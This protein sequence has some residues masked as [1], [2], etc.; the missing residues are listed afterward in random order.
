MKHV[1]TLFL[2]ALFLGFNATAATKTSTASG[3]WSA[4]VWTGGTPV[5]GDDIIIASGNVVTFNVAGGLV[6]NSLTVNGTLLM[7]SGAAPLSLTVS[8][9]VTVASTGNLSANTALANTISIGGNLANAGTV[10]LSTGGKTADLIFTKNGSATLSGAGATNTYHKITLNMGASKANV[11]NVTASKFTNALA[12]F[13]T[14]TNGTFEVSYTTASA[15]T[16]FTGNVAIGATC[17]LIINTASATVTTTAGNITLSGLLTVNLGTVTFGSAVNNNLLS[18]GGSFTVDGGTV[19]I[20]GVYSDQGIAGSTFTMGGGTLTID[21]KGSAATAFSPFQLSSASSTFNMTAGTLTLQLAGGASSN[22]GFVATCVAGTITG[23]IVQIGNAATTAG[24]TFAIDATVSIPALTLNSANA[25]ASLS[26]PLTVVGNVTLTTGKFIAN[27]L[28]VTL[29]GNWTHAAAVTWTPGTNTVTFN[30]GAAQTLALTAGTEIFNKLSFTGA[31]TKTLAS[32][33][34]VNSD[35]TIGAG[36]TF[37]VSATNY[38]VI[39]GGNW[40]DNGAFTCR[41]GLVTFNSGSAQTITDA[42]GETFNTLTLS[43]AGVKTLG[44]PATAKGVFTISAG[45]ALDVSASN[46]A[47][48][49]NGNWVDNGTFT[50][51][52]GTVTFGGAAQSITKTPGPEVFYTVAFNGTSIKTLGSAMTVGGNLSI[53]AAVTLDVGATSF[54]VTVTGNWTDNGTFTCRAGTVTF[55]GNSG[56]TITKAAGETF[57]TLMFTGTGTKTLGGPITVSTAINIGAGSTLDASAGNYAITVTGTWTDNGTFTPQLGTV[58]FNLA[59]AQVIGKTGGETFHNLAITGGSGTKTLSSAVSLTGNLS[60]A[61]STTFD[62]TASNF[63]VTV[64]GNWSDLGTFT[65]RS[66]TVTFNGSSAE[67]ITKAAGETFFLLNITGTGGAVL[68]GAITVTSNL[69]IGA[70]SSLDASA[71]NYAITVGG[72]WSDSGTFNCRTNLTTF[73]GASAQTIT[74][75]AGETFNTLTL[76]GASVKTLGGPITA[77]A[78]LTI[79]AGATLD[80]SASNFAVTA[81]GNWVDNG[82]FTCRTGTVTFSGGAQTI[83]KTPGPEIFN[84]VAFNGSLT[85]TLGSAITAGANLS[86]SSTATFDVS[87]TNYVVIV[88]GN[89]TDAGTFT[90]RAGTVTLNSNSAQTITDGSGET[91][92]TLTLTGTS[93]KTL[94]GAITS[95]VALSIG[96]GT[97]LDVSASNYAVT[98]TGTWTDNGTFT[99]RGGTVAFNK[100][101]AQT[102]AKVVGP[103]TFNNLSLTGSGT[104]TLGSA[105]TLTGTMNIISGV[106]FDVSASNYAVN[107]GGN[108]TDAGTFTPRA[109]TITFNGSTSQTITKAAGET[110]NILAVTGTGGVI[111]GGAITTTSGLAIGAGSTLDVSASNYAV[112]VTGTWTDNGT[113]T[114]RGGTVTF[115]KAGAQT[116]AK[117]VGP[118]TFNNLSLAGTGVK[119]LGSAVTL[120]GT[121]NNI[122]GVTFDVSATNYAVSIGGNWTN[123]GTFTPRTGTVTFNGTTSQTITKAAGE[124]FDILSITGTGGVVLGGPI[125]TSASLSI[126]SGSSLDVSAS[127]YAVAVKTNWTNNGTFNARAGTVTFSGVLAQTIGGTAATTFNN[128]TSSNAAGVSILSAQN[129]SG[130][131]TLTAGNFTTTGQTFTLLSNAA[132]TARVAALPAASNIVGNMNMQRYVAA[133][134]TGWYFLGTPFQAGLT[135][136]SWVNSFVTSGFTGASNPTFNFI[137]IYSYDETVAGNLNNGYVAATNATNAI[138]Q[139]K[140]FWCYIGPVPLT[141]STVSGAPTMHNYSFPVTYTPSG[142]A[143]ND[144]WNLISNPYPSS[145]DWSNAAWTKTNVSGQIQIWNPATSTY[146]TWVGGVG[147]NGGSNILSSSQAFWVQTTAAAPVL[148]ITEACKSATDISVMRTSNGKYQNVLKLKVSGNGYWDETAIYVADSATMHYDTQYDAVKFLSSNPGV[149]TISSLADS[150]DLSINGIP[151]VDGSISIPVRV[152]IGSGTSGTYT[153]SMDSMANLSSSSCLTL[154]D[155]AT[156]IQTDLKLGNNYTFNIEDTTKA[157]RFLIHI[158]G[159]IAKKAVATRCATTQDGMAIARGIGNGAC[160]YTWKNQ[161]DSLLKTDNNVFGNDTIRNLAAGIY[162]VTISGNTGSCAIVNDTLAVASPAPTSAYTTITNASCRKSTDGAISVNAVL[163]G[164]APYSYSWS[165]P[166]KTTLTSQTNLGAGTY[167]LTLT[168]ANQCT[169]TNTYVVTSL[170]TVQSLFTV[171]PDTTYLAS[172]G[173]VTFTNHS[174]GSGSFYWNFGDQSPLDSSFS[175]NH[176]YTAPGNFT[177]TLVTSDGSCSDTLHHVIVVIPLVTGIHNLAMPDQG[178]QVKSENGSYFVEFNLSE[179]TNAVISVYDAVGQKVSDDLSVHAFQNKVQVSLPNLARGVYFISVS[180]NGKVISKKIVF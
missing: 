167:T 114:P 61:A 33:V 113:F 133:G 22:L 72:N 68:G 15:I 86:I 156:G 110:F 6:V 89:W 163:G 52:A 80:V 127:N 50:C 100:A 174:V 96:A 168:D 152:L 119:T 149:P 67:T 44:G 45:S 63:A 99:P 176:Q 130:T 56:E 92:S 120:S 17:G 172:G 139:G 19:S 10:N 153:I 40:T 170:S 178:V 34:T 141:I 57:S 42:S 69:T 169:S 157:P 116:I 88:G 98:V 29:G 49:V 117:V 123:A 8:T 125:T 36:S 26:A 177:V 131:L 71:T 20:A 64:G 84:N 66:G 25:T 146:A 27:N 54:A 102:I 55:N 12:G 118:E 115:N 87:A 143:V 37:D 104:K 122:A 160:S 73:N 91:F 105:V 14:L 135:L 171:N 142:G 112:T 165:V 162:K 140:G 132:F 58:T 28:N 59:G 2:L 111:L 144:G 134:S 147:V 180:M 154:E 62:V 77:K 121:L 97:T 85:K 103:E 41:A 101:G 18:S 23:G 107:I 7:G 148:S 70:G 9:D 11:L 51:R 5:A 16:P 137:S 129:L 81:N 95:K 47:F 30:G 158:G 24:Q 21:T 126:G 60:I 32:A 83:T 4:I 82:T 150:S 173:Q 159:Q 90:C 151:S 76:S 78:I 46:Y 48:T 53:L 155:L 1:Y 79:S 35:L 175:T 145:I 31:G 74:N 124:T 43:G 13:L 108:W 93:T 136:Q 3:N 39:V 75:A 166:G 164:T 65:C 109:G 94:A 161:A 128:L 38:A 179:A 106:T 138:P